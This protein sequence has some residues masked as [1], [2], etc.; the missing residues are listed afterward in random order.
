VNADSTPQSIKIDLSGATKIPS[1]GSLI[2]LAGVN[3]AETNTISV[4]TRIVPVKTEL[5]AAGSSFSHT[6]PAFAVQVLEISTK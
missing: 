3:P 4:P 6:V 5:K 1:S 2:T